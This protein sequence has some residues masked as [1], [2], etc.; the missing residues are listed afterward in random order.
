MGAKSETNP[1]HVTRYKAKWQ[2]SRSHRHIRFKWPRLGN[3]ISHR[4]ALTLT[5]SSAQLW[6]AMVR[7]WGALC[8]L[9]WLAGEAGATPSCFVAEIIQEQR[10]FDLGE[11]LRESKSGIMTSDHSVGRPFCRLR[12]VEC[13][14][15]LAVL[16]LGLSQCRP[17]CSKLAAWDASGSQ[18]P[19]I[20]A[21]ASNTR[22]QQG[23]SQSWIL[24]RRNWGAHQL[25]SLLS[26]G[27]AELLPG[28]RCRRR[29]H[30]PGLFGQQYH[31]LR[32]HSGRSNLQGCGCW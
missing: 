1:L 28:G 6:V 29:L 7:C 11:D 9:A 21:S 17:C 22:L 32:L 14:W 4:T 23:G 5:L 27:R 10:P 19:R 26:R 3:E 30:C 31:N 18:V 13:M 2:A 8:I 25:R 20:H 15:G 24:Y 12:G 16:T